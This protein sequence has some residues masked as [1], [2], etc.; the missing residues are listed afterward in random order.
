MDRRERAWIQRPDAPRRSRWLARRRCCH[1]STPRECRCTASCTRGS[2][3]KRVMAG[4]YGGTQID[5]HHVCDRLCV[6]ENVAI[7][8]CLGREDCS[9]PSSSLRSLSRRLSSHSSAH[10]RC[11][12]SRSEDRSQ[13]AVD[14]V[15]GKPC[16]TTRSSGMLKRSLKTRLGR[17]KWGTRSRRA[18]DA[19]PSGYSLRPP[20]SP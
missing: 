16:A 17:W 19:S 15:L 20:A 13:S 2:K 8:R 5:G 10:L 1:P 9:A 6:A 4:L 18:A 3:A 7:Q 12:C 14:S 11:G